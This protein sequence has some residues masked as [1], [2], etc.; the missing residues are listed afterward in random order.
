MVVSNVL[1]VWRAQSVAHQRLVAAAGFSAAQVAVRP[2]TT[3]NMLS[4]IHASDHMHYIYTFLYGH[5]TQKHKH[6]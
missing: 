6:I 4:Y 3:E 5:T 2:L 1:E